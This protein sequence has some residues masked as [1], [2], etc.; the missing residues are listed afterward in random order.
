MSGWLK[1]VFKSVLNTGLKL[2]ETILE[3]IINKFFDSKEFK[4]I[5]DDPI[6]DKGEKIDEIKKSIYGLKDSFKPYKFTSSL[7]SN[8]VEYRSDG[9]EDKNISI[10]EY[11]DEI[12]PYLN[13][14]INDNKNKDEWKIQITM[15][16]NF[17]S[18]KDSDVVEEL[19]KSTLERYQT[20]LQESTRGSEFVFDCVNEIHY[21]FH[22]VDLNRGRPYIDSPRW[23]KNKKATINPQKMNYDRWFQYAFTAALN[24]RKIKNHPEKTKNME[25]FIDQYNWD[26]INVPSDQ[27][28]WKEFE[29]NNKLIAL[30]VLYVPHNAKKIRHAYKSKYNLKR[31]NQATLLIITDG[32]KCYYLAVKTLSGL[33][34]GITGNNHGDF[35]CLNCLHSYTTKIGLRNI[36]RYVKVM[37]ITN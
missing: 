9:D 35:Y 27:K 4:E 19:F 33:L 10:K 23:L 31:E 25:P 29:S 24:Y 6:L 2:A 3:P 26:E 7:N 34:R 11:L 18:L 13:D 16:L 28:D 14:I 37:S 1:S 32:T 30:N 22:K 17:I 8:Y 21:K 12:R 5:V 36:K 20:G 15:S